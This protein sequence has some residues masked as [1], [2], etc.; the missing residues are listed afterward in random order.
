[1]NISV[2]T[3]KQV[4]HEKGLFTVVE[5]ARTIGVSREVIDYHV[6]HG[7]CVAPTVQI[8]GLPRRYYTADDVVSLAMYFAGWRKNQGQPTK[9]ERRKANENGCN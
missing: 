7:R 9:A 2:K 5:A 4:R 1:M 6:K 3:A 8:N